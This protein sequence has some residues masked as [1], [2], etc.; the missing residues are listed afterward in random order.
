M[1]GECM[2]SVPAHM[3]VCLS[4]TLQ[5]SSCVWREN[6]LIQCVHNADHI[7]NAL[8]QPVSPPH[9]T[10]ALK[11]EG[12]TDRHVSTHVFDI[13]SQYIHPRLVSVPPPPPLLTQHPQVTRVEPYGV[14][15]LLHRSQVRGLVHMS[16]VEKA[17][18]KELAKHFTPGQVVSV[19]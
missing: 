11:C 8:T 16:Q 10:A 1:Y 14:F 12:Q 7:V 19:R 2:S 5:S 9:T 6:G 18:S 15:V 17:F 3:S 13:H 4:L